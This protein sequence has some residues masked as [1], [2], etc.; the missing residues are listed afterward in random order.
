M[1]TASA[2][3]GTGPELDQRDDNRETPVRDPH[4]PRVEAS[5]PDWT[6]DHNGP[7]IPVAD[8]GADQSPG[9]STP[10]RPA[11]SW[12]VLVLAAPAAVAVWSGWVGI[13]QM[14]GFGEIHP[15]PGLWG[16]LHLNERRPGSRSRTDRFGAGDIPPI[17]EIRWPAWLKRRSRDART[18]TPHSLTTL[19]A[20]H[21]VLPSAQSARGGS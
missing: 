2:T 21:S 3:A 6:A 5:G 19:I 17:S 11:R 16:S 9:L 7:S 13:G 10:R 18:S 1:T 12:P 20:G 4:G 14:T 15:L 8:P